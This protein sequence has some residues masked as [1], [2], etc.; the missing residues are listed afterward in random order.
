LAFGKVEGVGGGNLTKIAATVTVYVLRLRYSR[1]QPIF[2][3]KTVQSAPSLNLV[4]MNRVDLVPG[5]EDRPLF[6]LWL[7]SQ[8]AKQT[9][10]Q[11]AGFP[12]SSFE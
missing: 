2:V 8:T 1:F 11:G 10:V 5:E 7:F 4:P 12:V 6:H 3:A 9:G